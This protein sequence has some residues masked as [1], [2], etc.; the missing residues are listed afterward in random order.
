M[1]QPVVQSVVPNA[2]LCVTA[3]KKLSVSL[4]FVNE[5]PVKRGDPAVGRKFGDV[6]EK[7]LVNCR[8]SFVTFKVCGDI[9]CCHS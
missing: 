9:I 8:R 3:V 4:V 5:A 1:H 2:P 6:S 7:G